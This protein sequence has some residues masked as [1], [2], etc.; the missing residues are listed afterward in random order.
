[1]SDAQNDQP[2]SDDGYYYDTRTGEVH[3]GRA[4]SWTH[5][6]GPY[7]TAEEAQQALRTARERS[8]AWDAE[9]R[10]ERGE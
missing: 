8:E 7:G 9:D 2:T 1:M 5:R 6:M 4:G 3:R 10:R